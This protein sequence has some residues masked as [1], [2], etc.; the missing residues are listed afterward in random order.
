MLHTRW[1]PEVL[2]G[3]LAEPRPVVDELPPVA[4]LTRDVAD[5]LPGS[6]ARVLSDATG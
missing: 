1:S 6:V 3:L 4:V 2:V 5:G